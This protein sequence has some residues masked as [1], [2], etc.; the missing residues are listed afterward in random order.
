MRQP[1]E[2]PHDNHYHVRIYCSRADKPQCQDDGERRPAYGHRERRPQELR[3]ARHRADRLQLGTER[4]G[5]RAL[6]E[7]PSSAWRDAVPGRAPTS[8]AWPVREG[9]FGRGFGFTRVDL[10]NVPH[11]GVDIGAAPNAIVRAAATGLVVFS[12]E[13]RSF[14]NCIFIV[15]KNGWVT[16]Y[17]H[18]SK[19][20][21]VP[22]EIVRRGDPIALIGSTG[23]SR[24]P[25]LHFELRDR[26]QLRDPQEVLDHVRTWHN[27]SRLPQRLDFGEDNSPTDQGHKPAQPM[28]QQQAMPQRQAL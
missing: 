17:A 25:H 21:V 13:F 24:G 18:N 5:Q 20:T 2:H 9:R 28:P 15:H 27:G 8:L 7:A 23:I 3:Q 10:P 6:R 26:G 4:S 14:G 19:N 12:G 11:N 16:T 1:D 22:G